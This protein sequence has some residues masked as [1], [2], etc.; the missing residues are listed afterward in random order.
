MKYV[1]QSE[2]RKLIFDAINPTIEAYREAQ[3]NYFWLEFN[4][5]TNEQEID[6]FIKS[7]PYFEQELK[8]FLLDNCAREKVIVISDEWEEE[9][10][11]KVWMWVGN[12]SPLM[13]NKDI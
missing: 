9:F 4:P 11:K 13:Q 8:D 12:F 3:E 1:K 6:D 7:I 5:C 2:L 10:A